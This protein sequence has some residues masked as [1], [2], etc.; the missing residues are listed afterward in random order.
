[1][2]G[3]YV[4]F[5]WTLPVPWARFTDLPENVD[6]AAA[7][8]RTIRY[9]REAVRRWV[10]EQRGEL[11]CERVFLELEPDR[12]TE[13]IADPIAQIAKLCRAHDA[14]VVHVDFQDRHEARPHRFLS[15]SL[16]QL[17]LRETALPPDPILIDGELFDPIEHFRGWRALDNER[18]AR[19]AEQTRSLNAEIH[20]MR[21][22]GASWKEVAADLNAQGFATLN[23]KPWTQDNVRK[24][25]AK[26]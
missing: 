22:M 3:L 25:A 11:L 8:S 15:A 9:Q 23:G 17:D 2:P 18:K 7:K 12:A 1:M 19:K 20:R 13:A 14:T 5:Y 26:G 24:F 16:R 6:A 10:K 21:E 4:G